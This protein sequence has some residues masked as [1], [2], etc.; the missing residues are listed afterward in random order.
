MG[1][2]LDIELLDEIL[3]QFQPVRENLIPL[4]QAVQEQFGYLH[5]AAV[6]PVAKFLKIFPSEVS[7]VISFYNQFTTTPRGKTS[8]E[9]AV[10]RPATFEVGGPCTKP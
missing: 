7:G 10:E 4:L 8:S 9:Y 3:K 2:E 1:Q 6:G 5:P